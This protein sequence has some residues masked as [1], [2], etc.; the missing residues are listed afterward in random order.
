[1][2]AEI[3]S[4]EAR[5]WCA[6]TV[7]VVRAGGVVAFPTDTV[8]GIGADP[9]HPD[10]VER[11]YQAKGRPAD[12]AIP[13]LLASA[14]QLP[15]I[16]KDVPD[17]VKPIIAAYWPGALTIVLQKND[18]IPDIVSSTDT[19]GVRIPDHPAA[20]ELLLAAGPMAVTSANPSGGVEAR[21]AYQV[22][23]RIGT[24]IELVVDGGLT[25]GGLPSTVLDC[26]VQPP[27]ILR[28]GPITEDEIES[29]LDNA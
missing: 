8:Y 4:T 15:K 12:K 2:T 3:I 24:L 5:N 21:D 10:A 13:I 26:T 16:V 22:L 17:W 29:V 1:M 18:S 27:R 23:E 11:L 28:E 7:A 25:P 14:T 6:R 19:L 9:F 20:L